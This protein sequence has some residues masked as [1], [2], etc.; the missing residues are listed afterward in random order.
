MQK[1]FE[2]R[3]KTCYS[4]GN[5]KNRQL[6]EEKQRGKREQRWFRNIPTIRRRIFL[7]SG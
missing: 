3:Q 7:L 5:D 6:A 4:N 2:K 1:T